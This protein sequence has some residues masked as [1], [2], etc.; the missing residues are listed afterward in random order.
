VLGGHGERG[1]HE[2][3]DE[4]SQTVLGQGGEDGVEGAADGGDVGVGQGT[5][6]FLHCDRMV[7]ALQLEFWEPRGLGISAGL[8]LLCAGSGEVA[9][10]RRGDAPR[11]EA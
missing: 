3:E 7:D 4:I 1:E 2:L 11:R 9:S 5:H 6:R 10:R 8:F